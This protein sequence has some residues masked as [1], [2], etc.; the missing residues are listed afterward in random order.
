MQDI[1]NNFT[2]FVLWGS[3]LYFWIFTSIFVLILFLS[4]IYEN[5]YFAFTTFLIFLAVLFFSSNVDLVS[6]IT[7]YWHSP[8]IY[9]GIGLIYAT[10]RIFFYGRK[11]FNPINLPYSA[12]DYSADKIKELKR[13]ELRSKLKSNMFRW[14]FL[15]PIS[16]L[17]WFLKDLVRD[18]FNWVYSKLRR[19]FEYVLDLG[20]NS[21]SVEDEKD[22]I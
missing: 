18:F 7:L 12:K 17:N 21:V 20:I 10:I 19:F 13:E 4:D 22:D 16:F 1:L 8:L 14:W 11:Q 6:F 9:L 3:V 15:F 2:G 5:G